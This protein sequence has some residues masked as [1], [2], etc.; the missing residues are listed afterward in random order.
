MARVVRDGQIDVFLNQW[1]RE[2]ANPFG[3]GAFELR[4]DH[5]AGASVELFADAE[6]GLIGRGHAEHARSGIVGLR[7]RPREKMNGIVRCCG[8]AAVLRGGI[9]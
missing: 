8:S 3:T 9:R 6:R 2:F 5:A 7:G 4:G 1:L